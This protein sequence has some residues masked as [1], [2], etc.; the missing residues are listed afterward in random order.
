MV[1]QGSRETPNGYIGAQVSFL[2]ILGCMLG[3]SWG[4]LWR[5]LC[6]FSLIRGA[7]VGAGFQVH[8]LGDP[9]MEMMPERSV[10]MC[11]THRKTTV[12]ERFHFSHVY[13]NLV[14]GGV[15]LGHIF[16]SFGELGDTLSG[17]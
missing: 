12:L 11:Y 14:S 6:D 4:P 10:H 7:K 1:I 17:F 9:G 16:V 13:T 8:V 5:H 3:V 15:V 2:S